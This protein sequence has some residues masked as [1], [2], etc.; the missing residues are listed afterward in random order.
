MGWS[1]IG[2]G[3]TSVLNG[4]EYNTSRS[5]LTCIKILSNLQAVLNTL[6]KLQHCLYTEPT[7]IN[8]G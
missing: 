1:W 3:S 8:H 7:F 2:A 6:H 5:Y 4:Y